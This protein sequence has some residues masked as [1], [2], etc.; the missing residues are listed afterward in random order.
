MSICTVAD[1][2]GA[3][4]IACYSGVQTKAPEGV[5]VPKTGNS[6]ENKIFLYYV[7]TNPQATA[8]KVE[9]TNV[10]IYVKQS[11]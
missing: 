2:F 5:W 10:T 11:P 3:S 1:V 4:L 9:A 6:R 8:C 7:K